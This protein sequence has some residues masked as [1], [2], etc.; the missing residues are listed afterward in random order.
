MIT[1]FE[2]LIGNLKNIEEMKTVGVVCAHDEHTLEAVVR[3]EKYKK[4]LL[5]N[6]YGWRLISYE[7]FG[8]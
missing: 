1:S 4:K 6:F 5:N 3:A 7:S 2:Q 8:K